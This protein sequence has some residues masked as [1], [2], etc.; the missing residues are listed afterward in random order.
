MHRS[1]TTLVSQSLERAGIFM[2]V[3]KDH[4]Y[5]AMHFLSLNQQTLSA[6]GA[7]WLNPVVPDPQFYHLLPAKALYEEHFKLITRLQKLKYQA[8]PKAWGWKDPRNTFTL[9]MWLSV[10]PNAPVLHVIRNKEDVAKSLLKRNQVK[11]EVHDPRLDD[12]DFNLKL[13]TLYQ[14]QGKSYAA[15]LGK[16]YHEVNY[17]EIINREPKALLSLEKFVGLPLSDAFDYYLKS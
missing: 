3:V 17:E 2:G 4:N 7:D 6:A 9:P 14:D 1:G 15:E 13:A 16:S 11:G 8:L 10:F 5:E 12:L